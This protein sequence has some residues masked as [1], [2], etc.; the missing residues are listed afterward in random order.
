MRSF[1]RRRFCWPLRGPG[2][3]VSSAHQNRSMRSAAGTTTLRSQKFRVSASH[4]KYVARIF[5]RGGFSKISYV[6]T[7][8]GIPNSEKM[9]GAQNRFQHEL[10]GTAPDPMDAALRSRFWRV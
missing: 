9:A 2:S 4:R 3:R 5:C 1:S 7:L 8:P 6:E 10:R